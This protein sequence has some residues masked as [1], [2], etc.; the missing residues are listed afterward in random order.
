MSKISGAAQ[1]ILSCQ[2]NW[3]VDVPIG[4]LLLHAP[5]LYVKE[6]AR[7][8]GCSRR[9]PST[10]KMHSYE[11]HGTGSEP[12]AIPQTGCSVWALGLNTNA[13]SASLLLCH[14]T[15][16]MET[17]AKSLEP[18]PTCLHQKPCRLSS[19]DHSIKCPWNSSSSRVS[20]VEMFLVVE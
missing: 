18:N 17:I 8:T 3:H 13:R 16:F 4:S 12:R 5:P 15:T 9:K 19:L 14:M 1:E 6:I 11:N 10:S 7:A 2:F 20:L